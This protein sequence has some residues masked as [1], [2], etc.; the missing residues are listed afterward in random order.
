[1]RH[2]HF[3]KEWRWITNVTSSTSRPVRAALGLSLESQH[4]HGICQNCQ[5]RYYYKLYSY[6]MC[7]FLE[8]LSCKYEPVG[9]RSD[10]PRVIIFSIK[11]KRQNI[12]VLNFN[13]FLF[14]SSCRMRKNLENLAGI[15]L[16]RPITSPL[17][18]QLYRRT[19]NDLP[20]NGWNVRVELSNSSNQWN[21]ISP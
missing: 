2:L 15:A 20:E 19:K 17:S 14:S 13:S 6:R 12:F 11:K 3:W 7:V 21:P 16:P 5:A 18:S 9:A 1:M 4:F 10:P 8:R